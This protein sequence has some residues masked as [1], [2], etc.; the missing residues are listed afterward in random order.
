MTDFISP[1]GAF[2]LQVIFNIFFVFVVLSVRN[3]E[4]KKSSLILAFCMMACRLVLF[5]SSSSTLNPA[6]ALAH[7]VVGDGMKY[8]W[9]FFLAPLTGATVGTLLF[10]FMHKNDQSA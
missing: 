9:L 8:F 7:A 3:N 10:V 1:A 6:R 4:N 2:F 5:P